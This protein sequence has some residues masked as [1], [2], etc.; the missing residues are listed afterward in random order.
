MIKNKKGLTIVE[1][2]IAISI[3]TMGIAGFSLLF[4]KSWEN[5]KFILQSGEASFAAS[6]GVQTTIDVLRN[7]RQSDNGSFAIVSADDNDLIIY[8]NIDDDSDTERVHYYLDNGTFKEG[9]TDPTDDIPPIYPA[10]D[11]TVKD[12]AND[13]VNDAGEPVF[14]YYDID[15]NLLSTPPTVNDVKMVKVYLEININPIKAPNNINIQSYA[16]IRNLSEYDRA[17]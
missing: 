6:R 13:V 16:T 15:N 2:L 10:G 1:M 11:Q 3:F 4:S 12:L 14:E 8:S 5:N 7:A 9:W 17:N